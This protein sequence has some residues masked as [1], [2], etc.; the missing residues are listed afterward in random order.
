M[1]SFKFSLILFQLVKIQRGKINVVSKIKSNETPSIPTKKLIFNEENQGVALS[2]ASRGCGAPRG[3]FFCRDVHVC[4]RVP[5][6]HTH[7]IIMRFCTFCRSHCRSLHAYIFPCRVACLL[8]PRRVKGQSPKP[9]IGRG[10]SW[11]HHHNLSHIQ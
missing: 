4:V 2:R 8:C 10:M 1:Y 3:L 5:C 9:V 7:S 11:V 6:D